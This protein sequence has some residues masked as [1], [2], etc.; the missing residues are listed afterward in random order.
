MHRRKDRTSRTSKLSPIESLRFHRTI[1]RIWLVCVLFGAGSVDVGNT[2]I[3]D[4]LSAQQAFLQQFTSQDLHQMRLIALFLQSVMAE[5]AYAVGKSIGSL[6]VC[7]CLPQ[8]HHCF[9][10]IYCST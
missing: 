1:Y 7:M 6:D 8:L 4:R 10:L 2:D 3:N 9:V 5:V